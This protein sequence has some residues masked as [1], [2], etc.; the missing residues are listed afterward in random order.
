MLKSYIAWSNVLM[1]VVWTL[2]VTYNG[3]L[4]DIA[5]WAKGKQLGQL[6]CGTGTPGV[7]YTFQHYEGNIHI[8]RCAKW[9]KLITF[10]EI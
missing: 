8:I 3:V 5:G 10:L 2:L 6:I 9:S 1:V 4:C 7:D